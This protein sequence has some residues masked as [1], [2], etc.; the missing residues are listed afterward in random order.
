MTKWECEVDDFS[1][2][3]FEILK[4]KT[5]KSEKVKTSLSYTLPYYS[6][7]NKHF[8]DLVLAPV[9]PDSRFPRSR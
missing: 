3:I 5:L 9:G 1:F 8:L 2:F 4:F 7:F 6:C